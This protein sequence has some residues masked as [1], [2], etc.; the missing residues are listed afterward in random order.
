METKLNPNKFEE[1]VAPLYAHIEEVKAQ[2]KSISLQAKDECYEILSKNP[3]GNCILIAPYSDD[4]IFAKGSYFWAIGAFDGTIQ[5]KAACNGF[6]EPRPDDTFEPT[7]KPG[8]DK[9]FYPYEEEAFLEIYAAVIK[10]LDKAMPREEA[11]QY[12]PKWSD[13]ADQWIF[14]KK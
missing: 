6:H 14:V 8:R 4:I 1:K 3:Q 5:V 2:I 12:Y 10:I 11:E 9:Y 7:C 13:E